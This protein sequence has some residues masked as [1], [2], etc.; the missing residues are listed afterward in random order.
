MK[1]GL[2]ELDLKFVVDEAIGCIMFL[3]GAFLNPIADFFR[4][5][6]LNTESFPVL[7]VLWCFFWGAYIGWT[8]WYQQFYGK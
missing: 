2:N 5:G 1:I 8:W 6:P 4:I 3:L 7:Q